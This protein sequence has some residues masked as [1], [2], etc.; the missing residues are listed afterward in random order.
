MEVDALRGG[1]RWF[2]YP[3]W[4]EAG[5]TAVPGSAVVQ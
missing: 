2:P 4:V 3:A 5:S 1:G